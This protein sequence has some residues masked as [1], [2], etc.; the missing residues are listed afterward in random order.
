MITSRSYWLPGIGAALL[1]LAVSTSALA[2]YVW[3]D[4]N[5]SKQ[6]SDRPPPVTVPQNRI[7]KAPRGTALAPNPTPSAAQAEAT[8]PATAANKA[9]SPP[10]SIAEKNAEYEKLRLA[11]AEKDKKEAEKTRLAAERSKSCDQ[12]RSYQR[13]LQSGER[14]A[15]TDKNGERYFVSDDQRARETEEARQLVSQCK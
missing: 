2:Q 12:A 7:L 3:L 14:I 6:Y 15:R 13:T 9:A 1:G 10:Q 5:G 11:Q 4:N 8:Q